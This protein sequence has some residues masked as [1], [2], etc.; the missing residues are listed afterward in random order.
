M[1]V[2]SASKPSQAV[3]VSLMTKVLLRARLRHCACRP[4]HDVLTVR[5][6]AS[7][8]ANPPPRP[9]IRRAALPGS[10]QPGYYR[11]IRKAVAHCPRQEPPGSNCALLLIVE[12][13]AV[14]RSD[15]F[16][17]VILNNCRIIMHHCS[18]VLVHLLGVLPGS[19]FSPAV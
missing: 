11:L 9:G 17:F 19:G 16:K 2:I 3:G 5:C 1:C 4:A 13:G 14:P 6:A 10:F 12:S 8:I 15:G 18:T 7:G